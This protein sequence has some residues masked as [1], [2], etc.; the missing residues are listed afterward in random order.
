MKWVI[1]CFK[2]FVIGV[3]TLI[4][5][6]VSKIFTLFVDMV[7][8]KKSK[9]DFNARFIKDTVKKELGGLKGKGR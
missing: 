9:K 2:I 5:K 8:N 3:I 7:I 6:V 4:G 1:I